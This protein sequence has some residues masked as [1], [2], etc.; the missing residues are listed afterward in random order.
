MELGPVRALAAKG[1]VDIQ[2][3][4]RPEARLVLCLIL[5]N[6][7]RHLGYSVID[8]QSLLFEVYTNL[9][10]SH[11]PLN[12]DNTLLFSSTSKIIGG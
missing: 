5:L 4:K 11:Y 8:H 7:H 9:I 10:V 2:A 3:P 1:P 12:T 6:R